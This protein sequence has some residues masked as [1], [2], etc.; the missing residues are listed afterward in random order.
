MKLRLGKTKNIL[1]SSVDSALLAVEIYN[2]PRAEFRTQTYVTLMIIAWTKLFHAYFNH[3]IGDRYYHKIK[4]KYET[5]EGERKAWELRTCVRKYGKLSEAVKTNLDLFIKLRNK[6]EHRHVDK[7]ELD[8]LIFGECQSL[9]YNFENLLI[10]LFGEEYAISEN[11]AYSLQFSAIR[12]PEQGVSNKRISSGEMK[13]VKKFVENYRSLLPQDTFD[14][15]EFSIKLIQIPKIANASRNDL[16]VEFVN[17]NSLS[18]EDRK[19]F[20]KLGA[21]VKDK[22]VKQSVVNLGGMKPGAVLKA[23]KKKTG[24]TLS[25]HDHKCLLTIFSVRPAPNSTKELTET[26]SKYCTYDEVHRDYVYYQDWV[27]CVC[28]I[29]AA[30]K[31]KKFMWLQSYK[32]DRR[33]ELEPYMQTGT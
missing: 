12:T 9:L 29:I 1:R 26:I 21:L 4:G 19:A 3:E 32:Q 6:I 15:S 23:V 24:L 16:A 5:I 8:M 13:D 27:E 14:S 28:K 31:M 10:K 25:H 7:F 18:T 33:Y 30:D 2:K 17:W 11:L 20:T 22:I